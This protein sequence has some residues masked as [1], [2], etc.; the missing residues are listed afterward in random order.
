MAHLSGVVWSS[1]LGFALLFEIG[2]AQWQRRPPPEAGAPPAVQFKLS[3][4]PGEPYPAEQLFDCTYG[5]RGKVARFRIRFKPERHVSNNFPVANARGAFIAVAGSNNSALLEGL[6]VVLEA[7]KTPVRSGRVAKLPF[8]GVVMGEN[9]S[10]TAAATYL[11]R[12]RGDWVIAKLYL[13]KGGDKGEIFFGFNLVRGV[14]EFSEKDSAYG[15]YLV[16]Q[17]AKVL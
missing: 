8:D 12:P 4:V 17:L 3:V 11:D 10:R 7:K 14:G 1:A 6:K 9:Q 13:P 2:C 5:A 16:S 15:D